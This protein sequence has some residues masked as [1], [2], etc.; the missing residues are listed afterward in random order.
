MKLTDFD[1]GYTAKYGNRTVVR[2]KVLHDNYCVGRETDMLAITYWMRIGGEMATT[3]KW[4]DRFTVF[5]LK[6]QAA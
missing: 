3:H 1:L 4:F 5:V 6:E 2:V